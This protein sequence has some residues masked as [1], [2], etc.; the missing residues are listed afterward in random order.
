M[1]KKADFSETSVHTAQLTHGLTC[2]ETILFQRFLPR[3]GDFLLAYRVLWD[4]INTIMQRIL[5]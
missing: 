1:M 4:A 3:P 2:R 5:W